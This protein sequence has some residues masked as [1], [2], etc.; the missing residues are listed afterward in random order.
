MGG[1]RR[2]KR[3]VIMKC[4][5]SPMLQGQFN[6][7]D[8]LRLTMYA[9]KINFPARGKT[10]K[11]IA[12]AIK[13]F[14]F[15]FFFSFF[16]S[17]RKIMR[18]QTRGRRSLPRH[19]ISRQSRLPVTPGLSPSLLLLRGSYLPGTIPF[20]RVDFPV[21]KSRGDDHPPPPPSAI[22]SH[23]GPYQRRR[24]QRKPRCFPYF[25]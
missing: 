11:M 14:D 23:V 10:I 21:T 12:V 7:S 18:V 24:R 17:D 16:L 19:N 25:A 6:S 22:T 20:G 5:P 13:I 15:H 2:R 1:Q 3:L 8:M 4:R 9:P